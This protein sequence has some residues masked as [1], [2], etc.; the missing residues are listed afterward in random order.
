LTRIAAPGPML[1]S[2]QIVHLRTSSKP[3][4]NKNQPGS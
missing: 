4:N 1:A 3:V 2:I